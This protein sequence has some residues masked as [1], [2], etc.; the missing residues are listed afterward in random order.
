MNCDPM[1]FVLFAIQLERELIAATAELERTKEQI[2]VAREALTR[3][4]ATSGSSDK[5]LLLIEIDSVR[6]LAR[7]ALETLTQPQSGAV[8]PVK[9][10]DEPPDP[11]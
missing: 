9:G 3:F 1:A 8:D 2:R 6:Q 4:S 11:A 10:E 5:M 7:E